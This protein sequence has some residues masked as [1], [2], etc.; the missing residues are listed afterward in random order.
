VRG[1][2]GGF[3]LGLIGIFSSFERLLRLYSFVCFLLD[4]YHYVRYC[5]SCQV[6][7]PTEGAFHVKRH[8]DD[9]FCR[10]GYEYNQGHFGNRSTAC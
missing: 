5:V 8:P 7:L 6:K 10:T 3:F 9:P 4:V 2:V 1:V